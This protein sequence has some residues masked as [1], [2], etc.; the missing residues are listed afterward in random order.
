MPIMYITKHKYS[1]ERMPEATIGG[2]VLTFL[3]S[4][5]KL[6]VQTKKKKK[7]VS[8]SVL[9]LCCFPLYLTM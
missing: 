2:G 1:I 9:C 4:Y 6:F 8:F 3:L 5:R 7:S